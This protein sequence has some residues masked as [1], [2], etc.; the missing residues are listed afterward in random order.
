MFTWAAIKL[1]LHSAKLWLLL[2]GAVALASGIGLYGHNKYEK[3]KRDC[4][5]EYAQ[6]NNAALEAKNKQ[7]GEA[8]KVAVKASSEA[9][10]KIEH[11][12]ASNEK[13]IRIAY[14]NAVK[15]NRPVSC[16]LSDDE[17]SDF[18]RATNEANAK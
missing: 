12:K 11:V 1:F 3:G 17:L 7:L 18:L 15:E 10:K 9:S 2:G 13:E 16:D 4:Q 5:A 14:D 8:A 6:Q